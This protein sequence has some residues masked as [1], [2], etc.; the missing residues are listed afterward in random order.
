MYG[1][2]LN[3]MDVCWRQDFEIKL[4][5]MQQEYEDLLIRNFG[6]GDVE[7]VKVCLEKVYVNCQNIQ[8]EFV[9]EF[10]VDINQKVFENVRMKIFI[11]DL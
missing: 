10:K 6:E 11:E 1:G 9:D 5:I 3:D 7:E 2:L 4:E 8:L